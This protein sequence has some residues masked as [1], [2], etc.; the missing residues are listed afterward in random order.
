MRKHYYLD[1]INI[2]P[3]FFDDF[4]DRRNKQWK[5]ERKKY[6]FDERETWS[7]DFTMI[8][9]LYERLM[10]YNEIKSIDADYH[11]ITI[12]SIEHTQQE[13]IDELIRLCELYLT[14]D[15]LNLSKHSK[16]IWNI[17]NVLS[18]YMWW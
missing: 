3:F 9:L 10:M 13:W 18:A 8:V 17:W 4:K 12:D 1:K 6:G 14:G 11:K 5:K 16:R 2:K 7:M 15:D